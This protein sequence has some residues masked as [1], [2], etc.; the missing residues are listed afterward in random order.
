M[1]LDPRQGYSANHGSTV[2]RLGGGAW[3]ASHPRTPAGTL[4]VCGVVRSENG[5]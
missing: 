5:T 3:Q 4:E 2:K 1:R